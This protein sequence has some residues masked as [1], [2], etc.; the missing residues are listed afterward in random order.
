MKRGRGRGAI[1]VTNKQTNNRLMA[2][3]FNAL[4]ECTF[5]IGDSFSVPN[6]FGQD[7]TCTNLNGTK[8]TALINTSSA[9]GCMLSSMLPEIKSIRDRGEFE[10]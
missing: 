5:E 3:E 9:I 7:C 4:Y 1:V 8:A 6:N 2:C 10:D